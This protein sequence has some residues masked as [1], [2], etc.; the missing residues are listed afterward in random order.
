M[1]TKI[2]SPAEHYTGRSYVGSLILDFEDGVCDYDG[3]LPA[4]TKSYLLSAGFKVGSTQGKPTESI[5]GNPLPDA[6]TID[7]RDYAEPTQVGTPLRDAAVDPREEDF[8]APTNAGEAD[9][10]GLDVVSPEIHASQ[11]V[12][13]VKPGDVHV[14]DTDTQDVAETEHAEQSTDGTPV[15]DGPEPPAGN[16]SRDDWAVY[17][18]AIG[19]DPGNLGRDELRDR[20]GNKS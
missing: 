20:F 5:D 8:L 3:E 9:P 15:D 16:A 17:V 18:T 12:R 7:A 13:P 10:H 4:G 1:S 19:E 14:D 2:T 11:G 6:Q